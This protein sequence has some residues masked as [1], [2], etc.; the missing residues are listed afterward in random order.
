MK[1]FRGFFV[2]ALFLVLFAN[3]A[4]AYIYP[5]YYYSGRD[6]L[7]NIITAGAPILEL[8]FGDYTGSSEEFSSGEMLF[9]KFLLFILMFVIIQTVLKKVDIFKDNKAVIGILSV[10]IP[11]IAI[12]FMSANQLIYMVLPTYGTLG[13]VLTS[14]LPLLIFFY[15]I[16][17]TGMGTSGRKISWGFFTVIFLVLWF[18]KADQI[19]DIGNQIYFWTLIALIICIVFDGKIHSYFG[20]RT[21]KARMHET[22]EG[23]TRELQMEYD[24]LSDF[25]VR[26]P[27]DSK[28]EKARGRIKREL[29]KRGVNPGP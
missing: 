26:H 19:G 14:I 6:I 29:I 24:R 28:T 7:D 23:A 25:L 2:C 1:K 11:L 16:H 20:L 22:D 13:I 10:A 27:G 3:L 4:S 18:N 15:F 8:L 12:R 17:N 5:S 9:L 21:I